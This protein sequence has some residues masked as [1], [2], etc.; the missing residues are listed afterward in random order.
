MEIEKIPVE[1]LKPD[2][3][4]P[5]KS[6]PQETLRQLAESIKAVGLIEPITVRPAPDGGF[7][8]V[9]G[10]MRFR[11]AST[12][13]GWKEIEC[14]VVD[15]DDREARRMQFAENL[16][17]QGVSAI[18]VGEAWLKYRKEHGLSQRAL[19]DE[20]RGRASYSTICRYESLTK[21]SYFS[22]EQIRSGGLPLSVGFHLARIED[23]A[24]QD[25]VVAIIRKERVAAEG[26]VANIVSR[27]EASPDVPVEEIVRE[28]TG[29]SVKKGKAKGGK[30]PR[31]AGLITEA[32]GNLHRPLD[33][34]KAAKVRERGKHAPVTGRLPCLGQ[35]IDRLVRALRA[36]PP[37]EV[38]DEL[39]E[40]PSKGEV[41]E[42]GR[43]GPKPTIGTKTMR[44]LER[45]RQV[46]RSILMMSR[47]G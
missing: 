30:E 33:A 24:K 22:L 11:A 21:L 27:V 3:D 40:L 10:E 19:A 44:L 42:P 15:V 6:F 12:Y 8:I 25:E 14:S 35:A 4:N 26:V 41:L 1:L 38:R 45:L 17:R 31:Y 23:Q 16:E 2:P 34:E 29:K 28:V 36:K 39:K 20:L 43:H 32:G 5:R 46:V 7:M 37:V 13:A 9:T 47:K 18:E